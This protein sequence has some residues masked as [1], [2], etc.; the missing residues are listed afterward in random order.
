MK[1]K[2]SEEELKVLKNALDVSSPGTKLYKIATKV[3]RDGA[4]E[5]RRLNTIYNKL[6]TLNNGRKVVE[7]LHPVDSNTYSGPKV[8]SW[9]DKREEVS[10]YYKEAVMEIPHGKQTMIVKGNFSVTKAK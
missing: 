9:K 5:G 4:V 1:T 3:F 8:V 7:N 2:Y 6:V 10:V